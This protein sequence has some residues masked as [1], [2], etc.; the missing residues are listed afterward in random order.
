MTIGYGFF[1]L[2]FGLFGLFLMRLG[3]KTIFRSIRLRKKGILVWGTISKI[4]QDR[5]FT[6]LLV[7]FTALEGR[8]YEYQ[9]ETRALTFSRYHE[10]DKVA[11]L[12]NPDNPYE[13][14]LYSWDFLWIWPICLLFIGSL[15]LFS[16]IIRTITLPGK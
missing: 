13:A 11:V 16:S 8:Y 15:L 12:Y 10:G 9:L 6:S 2:L 4:Y 1:F 14:N 5:G 3:I 7:D